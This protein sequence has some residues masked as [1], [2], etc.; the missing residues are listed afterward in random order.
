MLDEPTRPGRVQDQ[1]V[2]L[3]VDELAKDRLGR[4]VLHRCEC[5]AYVHGRGVREEGSRDLT[6]NTGCGLWRRVGHAD[7]LAILHRRRPKSQSEMSAARQGTPNL[8]D[9]RPSPWDGKANPAAVGTHG[10]VFA[11]ADGHASQIRS[12]GR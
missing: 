5:R 1:L 6:C 10:P 2:D 8:D 9:D 12:L 11:T 4:T 3:I 7:R